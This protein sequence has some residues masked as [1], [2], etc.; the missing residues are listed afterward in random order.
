[1]QNQEFSKG[2]LNKISDVPGVM[3]GHCTLD[4]ST[5]KTGV[6]VVLPAPSGMYASKMVAA[7]CVLNGFGKS[8]GLVQIQELGTIE[9]PIALTNTL[10]VGLVHDALVEYSIQECASEGLDLKSVN[11]VV[12]ECNDSYLNDIKNRAVK[13]EHVF[14]AIHTATTNFSEGDV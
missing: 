6:T 12:C 8:T 13:A 5:S 7:A 2:K 11:P 14:H 10:N 9:T 1:M 4:D 3:V